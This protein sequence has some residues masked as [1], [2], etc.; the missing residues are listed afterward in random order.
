MGLGW[1]QDDPRPVAVPRRRFFRAACGAFEVVLAPPAFYAIRAGG[2]FLF[3]AGRIRRIRPAGD[4][5]ARLVSMGPVRVTDARQGHGTGIHQDGLLAG[6]EKN[7]GLRPNTEEG[8]LLHDNSRITSVTYVPQGVEIRYRIWT[9]GD[10]VLPAT[11][12]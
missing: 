10:E 9:A 2:V 11:V 6:G 7:R 4:S 3:H 8:Y 1:D 12:A 5:V